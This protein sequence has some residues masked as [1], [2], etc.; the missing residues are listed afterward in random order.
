M[1]PAFN[2]A[3][4]EELLRIHYEE[5]SP[6]ELFLSDE[7]EIIVSEETIYEA[8]MRGEDDKILNYKKFGKI[9]MNE[10]RIKQFSIAEDEHAR[11]YK[12]D[13]MKKEETNSVLI[14]SNYGQT[15][16]QQTGMVFW[17]PH[18]TATMGEFLPPQPPIFPHQLFP[19]QQS[20]TFDQP[21]PSFVQKTNKRKSSRR[22][23]CRTCDGC[24]RQSNCTICINCKNESYRKAC[25]L[26]QCEQIHGRIYFPKQTVNKLL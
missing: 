15:N 26:R 13:K 7:S 25:I 19:P 2:P 17:H 22:V 21:H 8:M 11:E 9:T 1:D 23:K 24:L 18:L 10:D 20:V 4:I 3:P 12:E 16:G 5:A 14:K 6:T